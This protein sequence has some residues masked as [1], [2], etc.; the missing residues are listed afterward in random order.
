MANNACETELESGEQLDGRREAA[1]VFGP[2]AFVGYVDW[3]LQ[4][5]RRFSSHAVDKKCT[6]AV[7]GRRALDAIRASAPQVHIDLQAA[8]L[9]TAATELANST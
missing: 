9:R 2:G 5:P 6:V 1:E 3:A 8:L 4:R 7:F